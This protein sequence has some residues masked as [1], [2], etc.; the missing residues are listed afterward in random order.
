MNFDKYSVSKN[1]SRKFSSR[2]K[3]NVVLEAI[4]ESNSISELAEKF[5]LNRNQIA[6][7]K[8]KFISNAHLIFENELST[9]NASKE[10][11]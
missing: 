4:K 7:W 9:E 2:F 3:A 10:N 1:Q 8:K 5:D 6:E 11:E